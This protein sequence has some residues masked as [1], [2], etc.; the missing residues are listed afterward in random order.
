MNYID[1][2]KCFLNAFWEEHNSDTEQ[3]WVWGH[4]FVD[5]DL[6]K[7]K[8]GNDLDEFNAH[9]FLEKNGETKSVKQL[10]DEIKEMDLD[11]NKRL[12]FIEYLLF[13]YKYSIQQFVSR[14]Q[15]DNKKEI[16]EA[17]AQLDEANRSMDAAIKALD[18]STA[19][20][21]HAKKESDIANKS[22]AEAKKKTEEAKK[23]I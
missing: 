17:Q 14:P 22:A 1:Q 23:K 9:R 7:G 13:R 11:F 6:D 2:G 5:L 18:E 4:Q 10:R 8:S 20:S 19:A 12:A 21:N 15:G 3:I 16:D